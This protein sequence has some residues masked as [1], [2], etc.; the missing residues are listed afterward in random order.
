MSDKFVDLVKEKMAEIRKQ[1]EQDN[2]NTAPEIRI[3]R[4]PETEADDE[5]PVK[6]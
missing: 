5:P 1:S 6:H 4:E 2:G 3:S